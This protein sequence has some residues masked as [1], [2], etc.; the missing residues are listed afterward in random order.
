MGPELGTRRPPGR[1]RSFGAATTRASARPRDPRRTTLA[2]S[3]PASRTFPLNLS[4]NFTKNAPTTGHPAGQRGRCCWAPA[5]KTHPWPQGASRHLRGSSR[6]P[7]W[8]SAADAS[9]GSPGPAG[10]GDSSRASARPLFYGECSPASTRSEGRPGARGRPEPRSGRADRVRAGT[11]RSRRAWLESR[12]GPGEF[13]S[14]GCGSPSWMICA[15]PWG[16]WSQPL[17]P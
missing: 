9:P 7:E 1:A 4:A 10:A 16:V 14:A 6:A 5:L 17:E 13:L 2:R 3:Y 12:R 11:R 15:Q 8:A